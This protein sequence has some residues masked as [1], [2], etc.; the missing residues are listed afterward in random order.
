M[1]KIK[2]LTWLLL[3]FSFLVSAHPHSFIQTKTEIQGDNNQ[4]T[5]FKMTWTFDAMTTAYMY[6][7]VD[8][9]TQAQKASLQELANSIIE[10][11]KNEHYFTYF[12][13]KDMPIKYK[14]VKSAQMIDKD[15]QA[16]LTFGMTLSKPQPLTKDSLRLLIYDPSYY[17]DMYWE[18]KT[19]LTLSKDLASRCSYRIIEPNPTTEQMNYA[20]SLSMDADPDNA[21]GQLFTQEVRLNC[22]SEN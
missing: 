13:N 12:Y 19:D 2:N 16:I 3:L 8:L 15:G 7:G 1:N 22:K 21:L 4:I 14:V 18:N 9:S 5:G 10:N 11:M 20:M 6:D 17:V